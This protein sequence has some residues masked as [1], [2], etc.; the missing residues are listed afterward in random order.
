MADQ[1][2]D[3]VL[4]HGAFVDGSGWRKVHDILRKDGFRVSVSSGGLRVALVGGVAAPIAET[5]PES[6]D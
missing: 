5:A 4:V 6:A 2:R 1:V 3:V